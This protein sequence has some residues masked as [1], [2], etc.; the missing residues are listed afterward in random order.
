[1][2][3]YLAPRRKGNEHW[4]KGI[5]AAPKGNSGNG[6]AGENGYAHGERAD[7]GE[8]VGSY[9]YRDQDGRPYLRVDRREAIDAKGA[10]T[11]QFPQWHWNGGSWAPGAPAGPKIPYRLPELLAAPADAPVFVCEGEKDA[12]RV[13]SLGLVATSASGGAGKWSRELNAW[14]A[15][16]RQVYVLEDNDEPVTRMRGLSPTNSAM[17]WP[18]S[19]SCRSATSR[20]MEM[21]AIGSIRIA[22]AGRMSS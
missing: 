10:R 12:N 22:G 16:K 6:K 17:S 2:I 9:I 18:R 1:M 19:R 15:H 11:K 3:R 7:H 4:A 21:S 14:F 13:A 8:R 5:G 20:S